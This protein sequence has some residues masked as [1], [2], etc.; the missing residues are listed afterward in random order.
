MSDSPFCPIDDALAELKAG[1]M[2][3]LVDDEHRENEGDVIMAA[4]AITPEAVNF[5]IRHACGRLCVSMGRAV[6]DQLGLDLLPG[7]QLDPTAI[8]C[9][10]NIGA[11]AGILPVAPVYSLEQA[12]ESPFLET[13]QMINNVQHPARPDLRVLSN[14]IKINGKRLSQQVCSPMGADTEDYVEKKADG[15]K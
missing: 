15:T 13:S 3:V 4:E 5:M 7:V 9:C 1:R 8:E 2:V 6:A 10:D 11:L 12:L 14:P